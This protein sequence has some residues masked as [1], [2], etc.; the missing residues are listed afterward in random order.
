MP[1]GRLIMYNSSVDVYDEGD[2]YLFVRKNVPRWK[3][4]YARI[5]KSE[6][7]RLEDL[8]EDVMVFLRDGRVKKVSD[9]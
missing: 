3:S 5:S 2:E 6:V 9:L 1:F 4:K 7:E 8:G